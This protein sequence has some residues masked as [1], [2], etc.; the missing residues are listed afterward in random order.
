MSKILCV[1]PNDPLRAY[2]E[3]G[4]IK[5]R[6]YNSNNFFDEVHIIS[7]TDNDIDENKVQ[8]LAGTANFKIHSVGKINFFN[9]NSKKQHVLKILQKIKP[10]IIRSYNALLEGWVAAY[11]SEKLDIPFFVSLHV[12]YDKKRELIKSQNYKKYLALKYYRKKIEPYTLKQADK[13]TIVYKIIEPYVKDL[14]G[15]T[16]EL[17]YNRID[18]KRFQNAKKIQIFDKPLILSVGRLTPRKNHECVIKAIKNLDVYLQ[19]IGDGE[20]YDFLIKLTKNLNIENKVIFKKSVPNDEIQNHYKSADLFVLVYNSEVEGLPIPVL[21]AMATGL[22]II[23]SNPVKNLSDG[24]EN[25]VEFSKIDPETLCTKIK[26]LLN[27]KEYSKKLAN[28]ALKKSF[29]FDGKKTEQRESEI[30]E[31]LLSA[32]RLA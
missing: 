15:K 26:K 6:Y 23:I 1:F 14:S 9:K 13:I 20:S 30:Y 32:K 17:L 11:C 18:L 10:H 12:Q 22:P 21:E 3:K 5:E 16:P 28:A 4:E 31:E 19:I 25:S 7:F 29:E 8:T 24:L 2:F 27:D